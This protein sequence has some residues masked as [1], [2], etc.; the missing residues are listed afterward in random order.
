MLVHVLVHSN[1]FHVCPLRQSTKSATAI[2]SC[3]IKLTTVLVACPGR[4]P[5]GFNHKLLPLHVLGVP[6]LAIGTLFVAMS[7]SLPRSFSTEKGADGPGAVYVRP[8]AM[9]SSA[10]GVFLL[11]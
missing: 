7:L 2:D 9:C 10:A 3:W 1:L 8:L 4:L 6:V 11:G 5:A